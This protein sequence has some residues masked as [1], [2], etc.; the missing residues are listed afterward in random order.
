VNILIEL[1]VLQESIKVDSE[2]RALLSGH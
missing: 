1:V 2:N